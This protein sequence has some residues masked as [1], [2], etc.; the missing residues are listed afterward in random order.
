MIRCFKY[1]RVVERARRASTTSQW[2]E[3]EG[4]P[5][6]VKIQTLQILIG[7]SLIAR[8]ETLDSCHVVLFQEAVFGCVACR[9]R[10]TIGGGDAFFQL[11]LF[12][13][14][15]LLVFRHAYRSVSNIA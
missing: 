14:D 5:L 8:A 2:G 15:Q 13:F 1:K 3:A 11:K 4:R 7:A 10:A 12:A 6:L 9:A